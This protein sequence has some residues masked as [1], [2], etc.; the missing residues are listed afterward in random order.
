MS[1]GGRIDL[2][3][4]R[5]LPV[6]WLAGLPRREAQPEA[7]R[8]IPHALWR[9][10]VTLSTTGYG[11]V[12]PVTVWGRLLPGR[13]MAINQAMG[14]PKGRDAALPWLRDFVEEMKSSGF[15]TQSLAR[16]R[17]EGASIA[18]PPP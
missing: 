16:H 7:F 4:A 14:M 18:P 10:I 6:G 3:A 15:V 1:A 5:A 9:A 8:S 12:V 11:D 13:F 2:M 17:I